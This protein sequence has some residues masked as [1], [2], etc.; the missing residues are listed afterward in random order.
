MLI[1]KFSS[2]TVVL[3]VLIITIAIAGCGDKKK[4]EFDAHMKQGESFYAQGD[5][6]KAI[7]EFKKSAELMPASADANQNIAVCYSNQFL[8]MKSPTEHEKCVN[9][10]ENAIAY[11]KKT[12]E[13]DPA[14]AESQFNI[15]NEYA[16]IA[17]MFMDDGD[18][19]EARTYFKKKIE[20][21]PAGADAYYTLGVIDWGLCFAVQKPEGLYGIDEYVDKLAANDTAISAISKSAKIDKVKAAELAKALKAPETDVVKSISKDSLIKQL[22]EIKDIKDDQV[23]K[24]LECIGT[25]PINMLKCITEKAPD[26]KFSLAKQARAILSKNVRNMSDYISSTVGISK[27]QAG[28]GIEEAVNHLKLTAI[29]DGFTSIKKALEINQESPDYYQYMTMLYVEKIK[30]EDNKSAIDEDSKNAEIN[31]QKASRLR[32]KKKTDAD[33]EKEVKM[34]REQLKQLLAKKK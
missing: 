24:V 13:L 27:D 8:A 19:A 30:I 20:V 6:E 16:K 28:K 12:L 1:K 15:S 29:D 33:V 3:S 9:L 2:L 11:Y 26:L 23:N 7:D 5:F 31:F 25:S 32:D 4:K 17:S 14:R 34:F 18:L 21:D 22:K 10:A